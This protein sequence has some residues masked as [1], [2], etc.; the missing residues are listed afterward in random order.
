MEAVA[1]TNEAKERELME[2][3]KKEVDR[4]TGDLRKMAERFQDMEIREMANKWTFD[5]VVRKTRFAG[6]DLGKMLKIVMDGI[7]ERKYPESTT[8]NSMDRK[9]TIRHC[10]NRYI[11]STSSYNNSKPMCH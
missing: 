7:Q 2:A 6:M 10:S 8:I 11:W 1:T 4:T 5:R 9:K 3:M